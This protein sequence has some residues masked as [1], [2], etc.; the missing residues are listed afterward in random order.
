MT[1]GT[2]RF[3]FQHIRIGSRRAFT[4]IE[5]LVVISIIGL[6]TALLIPAVQAAREA[7]RRTQCANNLRQ[8]GV[9]MHS[10]VADYESFPPLS[11][12]YTAYSPH[13]LL[14][15]YMEQA[16]LY[17]NANLNLLAN[18]IPNST[19][20][21]A[22]IRTLWCPSDPYVM[23][24]QPGAMP[25]KTS[26]AANMGDDSEPMRTNGAFYFRAGRTL[27]IPDGLSSTVAMSEFLVGRSGNSDRLRALFTPTG[28]PPANADQLSERC[29]SLRN[30]AAI[31]NTLKGQVWVIGQ[32]DYSLYT[33]VITPNQPSCSNTPG[34]SAPLSAITATSLHPGGVNCL[35]ADGHVQV[36]RDGINAVVWRAVGTRDGSEVV[37][38]DAF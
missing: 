33:H 8:Y 25:G 7:A 2:P 10:Y 17:N 23:P 3:V 30:E 11:S 6:L 13:V 37:S 16:S 35:F 1:G 36:V 21:Y 20:V 31:V 32:R 22:G 28:G 26:Y 18:S 38:S 12:G 5:V 9:A 27:L 24:G 34:S 4:L 19:F 29:K 15:S 14:L